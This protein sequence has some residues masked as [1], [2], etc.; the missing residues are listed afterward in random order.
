MKTNI[1]ASLLMFTFC[2]IANAYPE[3]IA[4]GYTTCMTCHQNG[5]GNGPLNDYGRALWAGELSSRIVFPKKMTDEQVAA[6]SGFFGSKELPYWIRPHIKYRGLNLRTNPG[7]GTQDTTKFYQ[8]QAEAG[9]TTQ[10]DVDGKYA[11]VMTWANMSAPENYGK[12][13]QGFKR[14]LTKELYLRIEVMQN[15]WL[16]AG[17]MDRVYGLRTADHT[18]YQ[19]SWQGFNTRTNTQDG[20]IQSTGVIAHRVEDNWEVALNLFNGNPHDDLAYRQKGASL[21]SE[22][23]VG[24]YKRLGASVMSE[25]SDVLKKDMMAI[26]YRQQAGKGGALLFEYGIVKDTLTGADAKTGSYNLLEGF[27]PLIRGYNLK[28]SVERYNK[29]FKAS[30]PD[31]WKNSVGLFFFPL[32]RTEMRADLVNTRNFSNQTANEDGWSI[33][34]QIH[35]SL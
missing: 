22:F 29:E 27:F 12:G 8:M 13:D 7:S 23:T 25:R 32:P 19:R 18:S 31:Y 24:E 21:F 33:L 17:L 10:A 4:Y 28:A 30:E 26:H 14:M 5:S 1:L 20:I 11:A 3:F 15:T 34:G 35:A 2:S 16:Y 6:T 9:L